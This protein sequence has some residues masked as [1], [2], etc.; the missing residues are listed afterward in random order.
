MLLESVNMVTAIHH[1]FAMLSYFL[2]TS[3]VLKDLNR[4]IISERQL[5]KY[6]APQQSLQQVD[7]RVVYMY[8]TAWITTYEHRMFFFMTKSLTFHAWETCFW[9]EAFWFQHGKPDSR[10][11]WRKANIRLSFMRKCAWER[12]TNESIARLHLKVSFSFFDW[13]TRTRNV[14][15]R[16]WEQQHTIS[17]VTPRSESSWLLSALSLRVK[18]PWRCPTGPLLT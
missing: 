11:L 12:Q 16:Y 15:S 17:K 9:K 8:G 2:L 1:T 10:F 5:R 3:K 18:L 6:G 7:N 4:V 13:G 14:Q